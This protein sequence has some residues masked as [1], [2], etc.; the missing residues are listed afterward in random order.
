M[1]KDGVEKVLVLFVAGRSPNSMAAVANLKRAI[2]TIGLDDIELEIVDV[3]DRPDLAVTSRVL[4][5]PA[6]LRGKEPSAARLV[7]DLSAYPE[8]VAFLS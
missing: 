3:Y 7:G 1:T 5:T 6:L 2:K 8:L 4:V